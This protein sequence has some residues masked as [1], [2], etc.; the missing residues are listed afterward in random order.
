VVNVEEEKEKHQPPA[1]LPKLLNC[2]VTVHLVNGRN[3]QGILR[4]FNAYEI[5]LE[6]MNKAEWLLFKH[7]IQ[8]IE[9]PREYL[10][11]QK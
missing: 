8:S 7:A 5:R 6:L 9:Y 10:G 3:I 2:K 4:G 11:G 1:F